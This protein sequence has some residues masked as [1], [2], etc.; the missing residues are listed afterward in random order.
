M[1]SDQVTTRLPADLQST[2]PR[3]GAVSSPAHCRRE[4]SLAKVEE[5]R[6]RCSRAS[7]AARSR[8]RWNV[9]AHATQAESTTASSQRSGGETILQIVEPLI[10]PTRGDEFA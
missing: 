4:F 8:A 5:H 1:R 6:T 2:P 9:A 7:G 10:C 3:P